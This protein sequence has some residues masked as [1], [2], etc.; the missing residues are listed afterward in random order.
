MLSANPNN[1][2]HLAKIIKSRPGMTRQWVAEQLCVTNSTIDR[3]LA[4]KTRSGE[5]N[6]TYRKMPDMAMA[7]LM[8][9]LDDPDTNAPPE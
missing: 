9:R 6:P 4:P 2:R 1:N 5:R 3:W 8:Y 7:L